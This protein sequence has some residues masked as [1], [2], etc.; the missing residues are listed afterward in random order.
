MAEWDSAPP[1]A[2]RKEIQLLDCLKCRLCLSSLSRRAFAKEFRLA[3]CCALVQWIHRTLQLNPRKEVLV[4]EWFATTQQARIV[5]DHWLRQYNYVRIRSSAC[6]RRCRKLKSELAQK[7]GAGHFCIGSSDNDGSPRFFQAEGNRR[8]YTLVA[9]NSASQP[10]RDAKF[11]ASTGVYWRIRGCG[12]PRRA[13][14]M[15][16]PLYFSWTTR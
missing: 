10:A 4:A 1:S 8:K 6:G 13:R 16:N 3:E 2:L 5:T 15:G 14:F 11:L 12:L 7:L 9:L